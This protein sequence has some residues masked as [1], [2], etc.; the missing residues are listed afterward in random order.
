MNKKLRIKL[1]KNKFNVN[2]IVVIII[3]YGKLNCK[4]YKRIINVVIN[5][6]EKKNKGKKK[7]KQ[8]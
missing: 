3:Y 5:R 7:R 8:I 1:Q 6:N 4:Y 2:I